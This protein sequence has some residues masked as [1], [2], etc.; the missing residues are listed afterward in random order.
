VPSNSGILAQDAATESVSP[1]TEAVEIILLPQAQVME[2]VVKIGDVAEIHGGNKYFRSRI[3]DLDIADRP[4]EKQSSEISQIRIALRLNLA[5][6]AQDEFRISGSDAVE[7]VATQQQPELP[8]TQHPEFQHPVLDVRIQTAARQSFATQLDV[9]PDRIQ[10]HLLKPLPTLKQLGLSPHVR[11]AARPMNKVRLGDLKMDFEF[12]DGPRLVRVIPA[13]LNVELR[14]Q[15]A[16]AAKR[17]DVGQVLSSK[18]VRFEEKLVRRVEE[19]SK[20]EDVLG[21]SVRMTITEGS[22]LRKIDLTEIAD[23]PT[24]LIH[25][26]DVVRMVARSGNLTVMLS[27]GTALQKGELGQIIRV[28]N[29]RSNRILSGRVIASGE[30]LVNF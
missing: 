12:H 8:E 7:V 9:S 19:L 6:Y 11:I 29:P 22:I 14:G 13:T 18:T 1:P 27:N 24:V 2:Q 23:R 10:I 3:A 16:V 21:K 26:R 17:I 25:P 30:V 4:E 5:G 15:V 28:R 20:P